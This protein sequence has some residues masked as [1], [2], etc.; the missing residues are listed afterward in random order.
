MF[1]QEKG[2]IVAIHGG[3]FM[4]GNVPNHFQYLSNMAEATGAI[5]FAPEYRL[6]PEHIYP[7]ALG[8]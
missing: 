4:I 1:N 2:G 8:N 7:A 3:G 6:A 5:V